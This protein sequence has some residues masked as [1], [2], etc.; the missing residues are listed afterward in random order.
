MNLHRDSEDG[1]PIDYYEL[2]S[3][4][5]NYTDKRLFTDREDGSFVRNA[6]GLFNLMIL[7]DPIVNKIIL[8]MQENVV[9][10]TDPST[11]KPF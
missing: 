5:L 9:R 11:S 8:K 10:D 4:D 1:L 3:A 2:V 7:H 6:K